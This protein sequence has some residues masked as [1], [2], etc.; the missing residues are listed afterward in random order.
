MARN[1]IEKEETR[2]ITLR[3]PVELADRVERMAKEE[4][5][6][7]TSMIN[8]CVSICLDEKEAERKRKHTLIRVG[9]GEIG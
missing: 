2:H 8:H 5:R 6:D 4:H 3:M 7:R 1:Q 9:D